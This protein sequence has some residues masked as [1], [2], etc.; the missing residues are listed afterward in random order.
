MNLTYLVAERRGTY[1][2]HGEEDGGGAT[3]SLGWCDARELLCEI[4]TIDGHVQRGND[5]VSLPQLFGI[6]VHGQNTRW[7]GGCR[8]CGSV[9]TL[10]GMSVHCLVQ[11]DPFGEENCIRD[12]SS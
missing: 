9:Q 5:T 8:L 4:Q 6:V 10:I 7:F 3:N 11:T 12:R 1:S 2:D